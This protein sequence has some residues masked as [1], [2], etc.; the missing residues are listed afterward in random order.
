MGANFEGAVPVQVSRLAQD[1]AGKLFATALH[2]F[3]SQLDSRR[4]ERGKLDWGLSSHGILY[5]FTSSVISQL[6]L[7]NEQC[8]QLTRFILQ[9][10]LSY[11]PAF[12][13]AL[14]V[15]SVQQHGNTIG[16]YYNIIQS[17]A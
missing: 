13:S 5:G 6:L 12:V 4:I 14:I 9:C 11:W 7:G 3:L 16:T 15:T 17:S 10:I 1:E 8:V 2:G